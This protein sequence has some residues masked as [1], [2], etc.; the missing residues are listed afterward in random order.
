MMNDTIYDAI[1]G[2]LKLYDRFSYSKRLKLGQHEVLVTIGM[3]DQTRQEAIGHARRI[4]SGLAEYAARAA[5]YACEGLFDLKNETWLQAEEAPLNEAEFMRRL[6][7]DVLEIESDGSVTLYFG[8]DGM[9]GG[10]SIIVYLG[11]DGEFQDTKLA[12]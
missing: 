9:F 8:D 10:H 7:F 6:S 5:R 4:L 12:G 3:N 2:E 1:L 11:A